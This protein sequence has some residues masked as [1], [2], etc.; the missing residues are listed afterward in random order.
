M[1]FENSQEKA[2]LM[3]E[4]KLFVTDICASDWQSP[5]QVT[6]KFCAHNQITETGNDCFYAQLSSSSSF[7]SSHTVIHN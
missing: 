6:V 2:V 5:S 3:S 1:L 7:N 4:G